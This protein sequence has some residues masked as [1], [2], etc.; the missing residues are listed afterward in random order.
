M[1]FCKSWKTGQQQPDR[2][3]SAIV[4]GLSGNYSGQDVP[5]EEVC[6]GIPLSNALVLTKPINSWLIG[7]RGD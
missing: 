1:V 3:H 4:V 6:D 2:V 7:I 5:F